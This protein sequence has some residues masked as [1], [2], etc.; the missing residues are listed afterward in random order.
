M[1]RIIE[2]ICNMTK[3]FTQLVAEGKISESAWI[4]F[5]DYVGNWALDFEVAYP[6]SD[7]SYETAIKNFVIKK[8]VSLELM[9]SPQRTFRIRYYEWYEG[10][11]EVSA[12][13]AEDAKEILRERIESGAEERP[14]QCYCSGYGTMEE[15]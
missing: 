7:D 3:V 6:E 14:Q 2:N 8:L 11:Y 10:F 1:N 9:E 4:P 5:K 15:D 12:D 13:D